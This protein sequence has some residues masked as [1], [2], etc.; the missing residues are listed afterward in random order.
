MAGSY[1]I[2]FTD[3]AKQAAGYTITVQ[4]GTLNTSD[5]SLTLVGR[6]FPGYGQSFETDLVHLLENFASSSSPDNPIE[7]QLWFDTTDP[8]NKKLKIN[9]GTAHSAKWYPVGG[10]HQQASYPDNTQIGDIWVDTG[11]NQLKIFNGTDFTLIG[12]NYSSALKSG[13]YATS[14]VDIY[15][16]SHNIVI[17]YV[18]DN[19]IEVISQDTFTPN[20]VIDGFNVIN[21]GVNLSSKNLGSLTIPSYATFHGTAYQSQAL[22]QTYP[23]VERVS[24]NNFV[25]NDLNQQL[26]GVLTVRDGLKIGQDARFQLLQQGESASNATFLNSHDSGSF[27]FQIAKNNINNAILTINGDSQMIGVN[28]TSPLAD[29]HVEGNFTA[30]GLSVLYALHVTSPDSDI[31]G[32]PGNAVQVSGGV[33]IKGTL[34]VKGEHIL[35]GPLTIGDDAGTSPTAMLP[36]TGSYYNIGASTSTWRNVYADTFVGNLAGTATI[37]TRLIGTS[38]FIATGDIGSSFSWNGTPQAALT[39]VSTLLPQSV[40]GKPSTS[41]T[42]TTDSISIYRPSNPATD[43]LLNQPNGSLLKQSRADFLWDIYSSIAFTGMIVSSARHIVSQPVVDAPP[44]SVSPNKNN[45]QLDWIVC[46]GTLYDGSPGAPYYNL[47]LAIGQ[48][49]GGSGSQFAVPDLRN[50]LGPSNPGFVGYLNYYIKT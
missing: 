43:N 31:G 21:A 2:T 10:I 11:N 18:N 37:A 36:W 7:G 39:Y 6:N 46:D 1:T 19:A 8:N 41:T 33:G 3:P 29:L 30:T 9:D 16:V 44:N 5:T 49:Y 23:A 34:N 25:R 17:N 4:D 28:T 50:H 45:L 15:G 12:P 20:Q 38:T 22:L 48:T 47:F 26:N 32:L 14:V 13:S 24:A 40:Y 42:I 35:V 27:S